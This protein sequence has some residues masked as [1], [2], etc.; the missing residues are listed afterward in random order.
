AASAL[1][2]HVSPASTG[3]KAL[4]SALPSL[5]HNSGH[6]NES[7]DFIDVNGDGLPDHVR[8]VGGAPQVQINL[9]YGFG[10]ESAWPLPADPMEDCSPLSCQKNVTNSLQ[11]GFAGLGGGVAYSAAVTSVRYIDVNGDG[12]PDRLTRL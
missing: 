8:L 6:A 9:G 3:L 11:V 2:G 1:V 12:L 10:P 5:E 4:V 7:A